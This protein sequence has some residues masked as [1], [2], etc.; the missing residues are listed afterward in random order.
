MK[1][2]RVKINYPVV[3]SQCH[4]SHNQSAKKD[5]EGSIPSVKHPA[6]VS[7]YE[8]SWARQ[9]EKTIWEY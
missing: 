7:G 5:G 1:G 6:F 8:N 3:Q 4:F 2:I 9:L